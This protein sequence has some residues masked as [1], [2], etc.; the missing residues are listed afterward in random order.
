MTAASKG[1]G[2][3]IHTLTFSASVMYTHSLSISVKQTALK[4]SVLS[5]KVCTYVYRQIHKCESPTFTRTNAE[6]KPTFMA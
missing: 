3:Y 6:K 1:E 5:P 2:G 4:L